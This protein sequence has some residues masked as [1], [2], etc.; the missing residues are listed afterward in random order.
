LLYRKAITL[1]RDPDKRVPIRTIPSRIVCI[2]VHSETGNAFQKRIQDYTDAK[3][4]SITATSVWNEELKNAIAESELVLISIHKLNYQKSK[5]YGIST[6]ITS[7]LQEIASEKPSIIAVFGCPYVS[8]YLPEQSSLILSY[9][10]KDLTMDITAQLLFGTGPI[11]GET[12]VD[13]AD[14]LNQG[15]SKLRPSLGRIGYSSAEAQNMNSDTLQKI[16][17]VVYELISQQAAP[18]CQ[19]M[20]IRN[21]HIVFSKS[22]GY[23]EYDSVRPVESNTMYDLASLTKIMG[24]APVLMSLEDQNKM[25][26]SKRFSDYLPEFEQSDKADLTIH[27]FLLHQGRLQAWIPFYKSTLIS[28]DTLNIIDTNFYAKSPSLHFTIPVCDSMYLR[29]DYRDSIY[30]KI[31]QSK[32]LDEKK[33]LY[34]DLGFYFIPK[35][36]L[37]VKGVGFEPYYNKTFI[38][39]LGL[40]N[41][42]FNPLAKQFD[43]NQIPPTEIDHYFRHRKVQGYVHDMGAAMMGGI[44]GHA[45]LFANAHDVAVMMQLLLNY[46]TYGGMEYFGSEI[47]SKFISRDRELKRRAFL[48]DLHEIVDPITNGYISSLSSPRTF[49]HQG[50]TGTC[51]WAD[52]EQQLIYV[53]LSNRTFPDGKI[54]LLHKNR[55]RTKI[56]DLVYKSLNSQNLNP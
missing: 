56:Q 12:P 34:S 13:V 6:E 51:V 22:Y 39:A 44:S 18:G 21:N 41:T 45:G 24:T 10:D 11:E 4:F 16:D 52:P 28:P 3:F 49:G 31:L 7:L 5:R 1:A 38:K 47:V 43:K 48:F 9:E 50:F 27:D 25:D 37:K 42:A 54:N 26:I 32:R 33:Y 30:L 36:I 40:R 8:M 17:S 55:Y 35:L 29:S 46:G 19:V 14:V 53:F 15:K 23:F 20:V 2:S